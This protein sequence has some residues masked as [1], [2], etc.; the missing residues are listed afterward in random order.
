MLVPAK[1][2]QAPHDDWLVAIFTQIT[3]YP[4]MTVILGSIC[5]VAML[6]GLKDLVKDTSVDALIPPDHI[7]F[8]TNQLS[9]ELFGIADP[10]IIAVMS[11]SV[12]SSD[13]LDL[14]AQLH[15]QI[16]TIP[17]V[18]TERVLSLASE[19]S[20]E[21]TDAGIEVQRYLE[22]RKS[23]DEAIAELRAR[24]RRMAPHVGTLVS[25]D[26]RGAIIAV[27][28]IDDR[29]ARETYGQ[30]AA[31]LED[32][33]TDSVEI[34]VSGMAAIS[35]FLSS[36]IDRDSRIMQP[37]IFA[38]VLLIVYTAFRSGLATFLPVLII[39]AS[40]GG[41]LGIMAWLGVPYFTITSALPVILVAVSVADAI[42]IL[43][44]Y[45]VKRGA[46]E[47]VCE[48]D[49]VIDTMA[50][51]AMPITVTTLTTMAGFFGIGVADIMP[52]IRYFAY[53]AM[54]GVALAWFFSVLVL[55]NLI[56]LTRP[57]PSR[58]L[59]NFTS[60]SPD[61]IAKLFT[62]VG[63]FSVRH[64]FLC[65]SLLLGVIAI[66]GLGASRL[67][68]DRA[69]IEG[70]K[71]EAP[72]R[73]ADKVINSNFAGTAF[74]DVMVQSSEADGLLGADAMKRIRDL[75]EF[76]ES[77]SHVEKTVAI[78]DYISLLH[79][80]VNTLPAN[81]GDRPLPDSDAAVAQYLLVYE[82][83]GDPADF[84]EEIDSAY[85]TA[86]IRGYMNSRHYSDERAAVLALQDYVDKEFSH[87]DLTASLSGRVN[88]RFHWLDRLADTHFSGVG[89]SLAL[90][91]LL[92]VLLFRSFST[93]LI[94]V[95]PVMLTIL[96]LYAAMGFSGIFLEPATTMFAAISLGVGVDFAIHLVSRF[97]IALRE[98]ATVELAVRAAMPETS[99][100]C[101]F[102]VLALGLGFSVLLFSELLTLKRFGGLVAVAAS[103]SFLSALLVVPT[104]MAAREKLRGLR[105]SSLKPVQLTVLGVSAALGLYAVVASSPSLALEDEPNGQTIAQQVD[106]RET[107]IN[108]VRSI[109]MAMTN[110]RGYTRTR[111]AL[112][113]RQSANE[114][115]KTLIIYLAPKSVRETAFLS[116]DY[117]KAGRTDDQW[118]YLPAMRKVRRIPSSDQGDYF[119]GTDFTYDDIQSELKFNLDEY[120]F[121][122]QRTTSEGRVHVIK[123]VPKSDDIADV[124]GYG[125]FVAHIDS[126]SWLPLQIEFFDL[127]Q[128]ALKQ[129]KVHRHEQLDDIWVPLEVEVV[130]H[131]TNHSTYFRYSDVSF[132]DQ[133]PDSAF[134]IAELPRGVPR[135]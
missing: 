26:E 27:E 51:M 85:Q 47:N 21:G 113:L 12:F 38:L 77:L 126:V 91:F 121:A 54:L 25:E 1:Q 101:F 66:A 99:R 112:V 123:G 58:V 45:Y 41:A 95:A 124:L 64:L 6:V 122:Y 60:E 90:I 118:L 81:I 32:V 128:Q 120:D 39:V 116:Y 109:E 110:R 11:K 93:G 44:S 111:R 104:L 14:V 114:V 130:N 103:A 29:A 8:E 133:L 50:D 89:L 10:V 73:I 42:H 57:K 94:A 83:S 53:F 117:R 18:R 76:M 132:P 108:A 87:G 80:A 65:G 74:L 62:H 86:L 105:A 135:W 61:L 92:A 20:I 107:G 75:Q 134:S 98:Q 36:S 35:G 82:A 4:R 46:A 37:I 96:V 19:S 30:I 84:E 13:T 59:S 125:S 15:R 119:L 43:T 67:Q 5:V 3:S 16:E 17:N 97:Q 68:I 56:I 40:A 127:E 28:L 33:D 106:R 9:K 131:Q 63:L 22:Q 102:N 69:L 31:L 71:S 52:P 129:V 79:Q 48:R 49:L 24:W 100:A 7:S 70:F 55:P 72:I 2:D 88:V 34:H 78:T 23:S 115:R